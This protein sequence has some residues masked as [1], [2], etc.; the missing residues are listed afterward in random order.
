MKIEPEKHVNAEYENIA[1][2]PEKLKEIDRLYLEKCQEVGRLRQQV[3]M[4]KRSKESQKPKVIHG[5]YSDTYSCPRCFY[6]LISKDETGWFCGMKH[7]FCPECGQEIE[8][9]D[10]Q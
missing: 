5:H 2:T 4:L 3:E 6:G 9:G 10:E 8:W 1:L 7:R